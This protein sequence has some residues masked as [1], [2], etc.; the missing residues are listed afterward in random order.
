M[1]VSLGVDTGG[2]YTDAVIIR[3]EEVVLASAKSLTTHH[4]L[5]LGIGAA[6]TAVL[7]DSAIAPTDI[8][9]VSISTTL[10]TNALVEGHGGRVGLVA[11]GFSQKDLA[12]QGLDTALRGEPFVLLDGGH[13]HSGSEAAQLDIAALKQ[14]LSGQGAGLS[15]YAVAG[16]FATRNPAHEVAAAQIIR[17]ITGAPVSASHQLSAKL[18]GPKRALT[19]V[20]N[21]RLIGMIDHLI[22]ATQDL[23]ASN[24]IDAPLKVVRGDGAIISDVQARE[25][26]IETI[27]SGPAASIVGARWLTDEKDALVSDI[28]GTTTDIAILENGLPKIDADG[29]EVGGM[30]TMVEAVAMR[31][32]GLGGDS[33]VHVATE[34][35]SGDLSLGPGRVIPIALLADEFPEAIHEVLDLQLD[36]DR[37]Q[38]QHGRFVIAVER[39][40][41]ARAAL[42]ERE[43]RVLEIVGEGPKP[44]LGL[45]ANRQDEA[46]LKALARMGMVRISGVTPSD[47]SHALGHADHWD[48]SAATKALTLFARQ[49]INS[50]MAL[51]EGPQILAERI[52]DQLTDQTTQ[53]LLRVAL[54]AEGG[55]LGA[56]AT[57]YANHPLIRAGLSD[58]KGLVAL[59]AGLNLPVI[60]LGAS[61]GTY[62]PAVGARLSTG[63]VLPEHAGVANAIGAVVG[64]ITM[65]ESG[66][67]EAAGEG[68][69]RIYLEDGPKVFIDEVQAIDALEL[70]LTQRAEA[71]ART[72][73]AQD[74][75]SFLTLDVQRANL[76]GR[77]VFV[78]A[79]L[80][81]ASSGRPRVA[82]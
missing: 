51:A 53:A 55:D 32:F 3:D 30:R 66:E 78:S 56:Q 58:H 38:P 69:F 60:G 47:A 68:Q 9:L 70:A 37:S 22:T 11:I 20:L 67:I 21:A 73:G 64:Q 25:T 80:S 14:W 18:G 6:I 15:G 46:S 33:E 28:G 40:A 65:R 27:L 57:R 62:Y 79:S 36:A 5:A 44:V 17:E 8:S 41:A 45:L 52:I 10:A 48:N 59:K 31:T 24:G 75:Q 42:T 12:R 71:A 43:A 34:G 19:A 82:R 23:M 4:D 50:G 39:G 16:Q 63:T 76:E 49:R 13:N 26:P 81:V 2:T 77:E 74:V 54:D 1:R 61:A 72:A 7:R 29:A 35:L